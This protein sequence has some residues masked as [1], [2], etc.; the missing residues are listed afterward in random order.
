[1]KNTKIVDI[2]KSK[3]TLV[4]LKEDWNIIKKQTS[5]PK[6]TLDITDNDEELY[7]SGLKLKQSGYT[8]IEVIKLIEDFRNFET[9]YQHRYQS[10]QKNQYLSN[11]FYSNGRNSIWD[12]FKKKSGLYSKSS[13]GCDTNQKT[14]EHFI[15]RKLTSQILYTIRDTNKLCFLDYVELYELL[16][17]TIVLSKTEHNKITTRTRNTSVPSFIIYEIEDIE[18]IGL[19]EYIVKISERLKS[20]YKFDL[21]EYFG[22]EPN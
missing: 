6:L 14:D 13:V 19:K 8:D 2:D 3:I 4:K 9:L 10:I 21:Y 20:K 18:I 1:M 16:S 11:L 15:P 5:K 7:D 22:I 17:K 12:N